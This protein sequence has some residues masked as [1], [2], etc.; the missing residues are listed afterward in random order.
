MSVTLVTTLEEAKA[1]IESV[2]GTPIHD[3]DLETAEY[4]VPIEFEG[5]D[6]IIVFSTH[7]P[8]SNLRMRIMNTSTPDEPC[9][10]LRIAEKRIH[11]TEKI[12]GKLAFVRTKSGKPMKCTIPEK[13]AS[14]W[15]VRLADKMYIALGLEHAFLEDDAVLPCGS[16]NARFLTLRIFQGKFSYYESFGYK[17]LIRKNKLIPDDYDR[18]S[19]EDD[20]ESLREFPVVDL[21][22]MVVVP[23]KD[24]NLTAS[25]ST[26]SV[27]EQKRKLAKVVLDR[28]GSKFETLGDLLPYLWTEEGC[29]NYINVVS[30][31]E[32]AARKDVDGEYGEFYTFAPALYRVQFIGGEYIKSLK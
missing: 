25:K 18:R 12:V 19:Y 11:D 13:N 27:I 26:I 17:V 31:M 16:T 24:T 28:A 9:L 23:F 29:M 1:L 7:E 3:I 21:R 4:A 5:F 6:T 30:F 2:S 14:S 32:T 20:A 10:D 22:C 8:S 15:M